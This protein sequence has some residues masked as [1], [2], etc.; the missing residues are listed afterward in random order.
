M[1]FARKITP[2]YI[3]GLPQ[4]THEDDKVVCQKWRNS[5]NNARLL[6]FRRLFIEGQTIAK[7]Y[8]LLLSVLPEK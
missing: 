7:S 3:C 5:I 4:K 2:P 1:S 6:D 8:R